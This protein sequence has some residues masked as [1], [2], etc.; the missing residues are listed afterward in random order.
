MISCNEDRLF[1]T[2][3]KDRGYIIKATA[4]RENAS[5]FYLFPHD[6]GSHPFEFIIGYYGDTEHLP[7]GSLRATNTHSTPTQPPDP[8]PRFLQA[9][10]NRFGY[11]Q[12]PLGLRYNADL[13]NSHFT[14]HSRLIHSISPVDPINWTHGQDIFYICCNQGRG[15]KNGYI[16][17]KDSTNHGNVVW[18]S[19]CKGSMR[20]HDDQHIFMLFRLLPFNVLRGQPDLPGRRDVGGLRPSSYTPQEIS[21]DGRSGSNE[22]PLIG[23]D[24]SMSN[25]NSVPTT[26]VQQCSV[27]N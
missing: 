1:W 7:N 8:I 13:R 24:H 2:V 18:T 5:P 10:T 11:D 25:D 14:L 4:V 19:G 12:G 6:D 3:D 9:N 21:R 27:K 17:I 26:K 15:R 22:M 16:C 23:V 20:R